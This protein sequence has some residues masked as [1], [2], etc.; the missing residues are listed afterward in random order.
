MIGFMIKT[1]ICNR[2]ITSF[3]DTQ[4][5]MIFDTQQRTIS[6]MTLNKDCDVENF[7]Q[8]LTCKS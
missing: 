3:T 5:N 4:K 1:R 6:N 2:H 8:R 7:I